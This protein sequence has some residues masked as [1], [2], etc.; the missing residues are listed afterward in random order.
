MSGVV[1]IGAGFTAQ[2]AV[3]TNGAN[4]DEPV[5]IIHGPRLN[6]V[7]ENTAVFSNS[8]YLTD[9]AVFHQLESGYQKATAATGTNHD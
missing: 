4:Q 9:R 2:R 8:N 6:G 5:W 3:I 1:S 7:Q